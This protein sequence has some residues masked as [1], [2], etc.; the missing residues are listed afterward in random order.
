MGQPSRTIPTASRS[1]KAKYDYEKATE[2]LEDTVLKAPIRLGTVVRVNT[3]VGRFADKMENDAPL[4]VIE[5]LDQLELEIKVSEYSIGK[6]AL[7][8]EAEISADILRLQRSTELSTRS[9]RPE[10]KKAADP[11]NVSSR[12][13]SGSRTAIRS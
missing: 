10:R 4:F 9:P 6:V 1:K 2:S 3:K 8:Q 7:G 13:R 5:N 11:P 12:Q